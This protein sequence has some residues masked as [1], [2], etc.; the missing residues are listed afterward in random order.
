MQFLFL[1]LA[2][3]SAQCAPSLKGV[4]ID[5]AQMNFWWLKKK[6]IWDI[7]TELH[8]KVPKSTGAKLEGCSPHKMEK[9]NFTV[10]SPPWQWAQCSN[11]NISFIK[12][13][14]FTSQQPTR[15]TT[16]FLLQPMLRF[17]SRCSQILMRPSVKTGASSKVPYG[18]VVTVPCLCTSVVYTQKIY[19]RK[20]DGAF[21]VRAGCA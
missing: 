9:L 7:C 13:A 11:V 8:V 14:T 4:N 2:R 18:F 16:H 21:S 19:T 17:C 3:G 12:K 15:K 1:W 5:C 10:K 20:L 6:A